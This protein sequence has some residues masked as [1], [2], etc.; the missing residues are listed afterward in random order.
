MKHWPAF[1]VQSQNPVAENNLTRAIIRIQDKR[2]DEP[3]D[4][5]KLWAGEPQIQFWS[6]EY[7]TQNE[8]WMG[9]IQ[10][11]A[12][13]ENQDNDIYLGSMNVGGGLAFFSRKKEWLINQGRF[14]PV[15]TMRVLDDK[16]TIGAKQTENKFAVVPYWNYDLANQFAID[17]REGTT[18]ALL[19][20]FYKSTGSVDG[21]GKRTSFSWHIELPNL[22]VSNEYET[23]GAFNFCSDNTS[24][25]PGEEGEELTR[26]VTFLRTGKVGIKNE[27]PKVEL[28]VIGKAS[29]NDPAT[30]NKIVT[31]THS[32]YRLAVEGKLVAKEIIVTESNW[33]TWPDYVFKPN[34]NLMSLLDLEKSINQNGHLP[35]MPNAQ[36]IRDN[37]INISEVQ[38]K[39]LEKIEEL[40]LY[41]IEMKKENEL[42][43]Q[44][45]NKL[46]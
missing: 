43:K 30:P 31:V 3:S 12:D 24:V 7:H 44:E 29:I 33:N 27:N 6:N 10:G 34:Y 39:L 42:L 36:D 14:S 19:T 40:T 18:H 5:S 20:K 8:W 16:V 25:A 23:L 4:E 28:H 9:S 35:G 45:I 46:K 22:N 21:N 32:D 11:V 17:H 41:M 38:A 13:V 2:Y 37:G 15:E 26:L 1:L